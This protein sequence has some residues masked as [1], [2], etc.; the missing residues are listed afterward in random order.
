[1]DA[2]P[3][4]GRGPWERLALVTAVLLRGTDERKNNS[5]GFPSPPCPPAAAPPALSS[6][7]PQLF[8]LRPRCE[9]APP[10]PPPRH[11][12]APFGPARPNGRWPVPAR[13]GVTLGSGHLYTH[14]LSAQ[15]PQN[16]AALRCLERNER[17]LLV[18]PAKQM[19]PHVGS[20]SAHLCEF[21][22]T[23][24]QLARPGS[25]GDCVGRCPCVPVLPLQVA[26]VSGHRDTSAKGSE[27]LQAA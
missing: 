3:G 18:L 21:V 5:R 6:P 1:M 19:M 17:F 14:C 23:Q 12:P 24:T 9:R 25:W 22:P 8:H 2:Q 15:H 10:I 16:L 20:H 4:A 13:E 11:R 26:K 27:F 7:G